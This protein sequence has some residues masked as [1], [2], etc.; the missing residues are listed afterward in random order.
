MD[1]YKIILKHRF[2]KDEKFDGIDFSPTLDTQKKLVN[3]DLIFRK[4]GNEFL[5]LSTDD[6]GLN[7]GNGFEDEVLRFD[8]TCSD[9]FFYNYTQL[10]LSRLQSEVIYFSSR[11]NQ[12]G[13]DYLEK[14]DGLRNLV[15]MVGDFLKLDLLPGE[16][17]D[18]FTIIDHFGSI[19]DVPDDKIN[20][21][22]SKAVFN[23]NDFVPGYYE[24]KKGDDHFLNFY[25]SPEGDRFF[26][27]GILELSLK[28]LVS[29][30]VEIIFESRKTNWR[31]FLMGSS[32][33]DL[34]KPLVI[35]GDKSFAFEKVVDEIQLSK[36]MYWTLTLE[37]PL[38]LKQEMAKEETCRLVEANGTQHIELIKYLP[39]ANPTNIILS[40]DGVS[41]YSDIFIY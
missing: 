1:I 19:V 38:S 10:D 14:F 30:E 32:F 4:I 11:R 9:T 25:K 34:N 31:Y 22:T 6:S 28:E 41:F 15:V 40:D 8:M 13:D 36:E 39:I 2:F 18:V 5:I 27:F 17:T 20:V 23:V 7:F 3:Y 24:V 35:K 26:Q 12:F 37:E 33:K 21:N 29:K 16:N